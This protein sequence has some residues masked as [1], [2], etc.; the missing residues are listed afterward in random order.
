MYFMGLKDNGF[1]NPMFDASSQSVLYF[2]FC[3]IKEQSLRTIHDFWKGRHVG[4]S[5]N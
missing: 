3:R 2:R 1:D 4:L 5:L